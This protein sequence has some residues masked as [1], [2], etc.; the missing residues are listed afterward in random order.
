MGVFVTEHS[1]VRSQRGRVLSEPLVSYWLASTALSVS[2]GVVL[3]ARTNFV[4]VSADAACLFG[5]TVSTV[6]TATVLTSTNSYRLPANGPPE[7]L[8]VPIGASSTGGAWR[9]LAGATA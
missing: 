9:S 8:G 5:F 2:T 6:S 1:G 4:R 7:M 3:N